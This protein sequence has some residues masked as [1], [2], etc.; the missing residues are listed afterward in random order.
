MREL[1]MWNKFFESDVFNIDTEKVFELMKKHKY[2]Y[3]AK[4]LD[5]GGCV[6]HIPN[7]KFKPNF[8][9]TDILYTVNDDGY[10]LTCDNTDAEESVECNDFSIGLRILNEVIYMCLSIGLSPCLMKLYDEN[11]NEIDER[12]FIDK[13]HIN[14]SE[15]KSILT[16]Y[17][18][19][20]ICGDKDIDTILNEISGLE[21]EE[22]FRYILSDIQ[23]LEINN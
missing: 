20:F 2:K 4:V 6:V 18:S 21:V 7:R 5:G 15:N 12:T 22:D 1:T 16:N 23:N 11:D 19:D 9:E 10:R 14:E 17:F 8:K 13:V 3:Y